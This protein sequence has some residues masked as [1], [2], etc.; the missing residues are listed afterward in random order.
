LDHSR[1]FTDELGELGIIEPQPGQS[2]ADAIVNR[3][4]VVALEVAVGVAE[5]TG[6]EGHERLT[7]LVAAHPL[8]LVE[9]DARGGD[10]EDVGPLER[11]ADAAFRHDAANPRVHEP[12]YVAI[13]TGR[14]HVAQFGSQLGGGQCSVAEE[15]LHD[16]QADGVEQ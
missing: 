4:E 13:D 1:P 7:M 6:D 14:R 9:A 12:R 15:R 3:V 16:P 10:T 8:E 2:V 11:P 5:Q